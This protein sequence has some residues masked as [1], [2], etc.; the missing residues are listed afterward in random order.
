MRSRAPWA[1]FLGAFWPFVLGSILVAGGLAA[2]VIGYLGV[3]GT[4]Y[5]PLQMPYLVSGA[6]LG[7]ALVIVGTA[8]F[9]VQV[10]TRQT[11]LLRRLLSEVEAPPQ[12]ALPAESTAATEKLHPDGDGAA[13]NGSSVFAVRGGRWFHRQGCILLEG[14]SSRAMA[15]REAEDLGLAPCR[16]CDPVVPAG[17]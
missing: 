4:V 7:L 2:I 11:R 15:P 16:L 6:V 8:L 17:T 1:A 5:V 9:V 3:S 12:P 13:V 14:K 10:L